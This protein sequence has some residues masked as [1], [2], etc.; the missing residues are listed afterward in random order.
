M[1][2]PWKRKVRIKVNDNLLTSMIKDLLSQ[3]T[4]TWKYSSMLQEL[5]IDRC[6][7]DLKKVQRDIERWIYFEAFS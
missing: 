7:V 1:K 6:V 3:K 2:I 5:K 4:S